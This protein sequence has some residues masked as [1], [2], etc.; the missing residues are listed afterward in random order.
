MQNFHSVAHVLLSLCALLISVSASAA[1]KSELW[2]RW[3]LH[4]AA[5]TRVLNHTPWQDF[6]TRYVV[7]GADGI[8]RVRYSEV[9]F[10]DKGL[11]RVY[12]DQLQRT[13]VSKLRRDEQR[14]YWINLYNA[15]TVKL[16]LDR[17]PLQSILDIQIS[18]GFFAKGP[19]GA[20]LLKVEDETLSLDDIE[21]RILR[22]IWNDPRTH[23]ALNCASLGCPNL[24]TQAYTVG[25]MESLLDAGARA[26]INHA[27][28]AR[29][30]GGHLIVSSIYD[31][32]ETDF[33]G[34]AAGVIAHLRAFAAPP[35]ATNLQGIA[36]IKD[37]VYD[38][39]LNDLRTPDN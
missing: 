22:P 19:W 24:A 33:G 39:S 2:P 13:P 27:R 21:H 4:D 31:W 30:E 11:L 14:A 17:Y 1:P 37:H 23:Y 29:V 8:T 5:S 3:N 28:G 25:N 35:L 16:V 6:L 20:R 38:W 26:Y 34:N 18:P 15:Q 12:L 36:K 32:F 7:L 9:A 10:E